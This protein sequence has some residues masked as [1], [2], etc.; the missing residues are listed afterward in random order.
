V[1]EG[2][3]NTEQGWEEPRRRLALL[4]KKDCCDQQ[5]SGCSDNATVTIC[6]TRLREDKT[7]SNTEFPLPNELPD[8]LPHDQASDQAMVL[9]RNR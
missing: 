3:G 1:S 4:C 7:T 2:R 6:V 8:D 5:L 9:L